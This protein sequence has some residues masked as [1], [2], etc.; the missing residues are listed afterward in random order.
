VALHPGDAGSAAVLGAAERA[1]KTLLRTRAPETYAR[2]LGLD[3]VADGEHATRG[4]C[5]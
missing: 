3:D 1:V 4:A 2:A 5:A